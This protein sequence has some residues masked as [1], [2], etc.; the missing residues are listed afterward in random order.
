MTHTLRYQR[1]RRS[2]GRRSRVRL[3]VVANLTQQMT[4]DRRWLWRAAIDISLECRELLNLKT[5]AKR[6][7][8]ITPAQKLGAQRESRYTLRNGISNAS[9]VCYGSSASQTLLTFLVHGNDAA[10]SA[11]S[12][13]GLHDLIND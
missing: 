13:L 12:G 1:P 9:A 4:T 11:A 3:L 10:S 6:A 2:M 7:A 8:S 5:K